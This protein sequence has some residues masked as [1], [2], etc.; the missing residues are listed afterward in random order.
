MNLIQEMNDKKALT[1]QDLYQTISKIME[2][3]PQMADYPV[4]LSENINQKGILVPTLRH[5]Y[6]DDIIIEN[7]VQLAANIVF[8]Q[9]D[10]GIV[11]GYVIKTEN[12]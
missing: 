3:F 7:N 8:S 1:L 11:I 12:E 2:R 10:K 9:V 4:I 5:M 6:Q